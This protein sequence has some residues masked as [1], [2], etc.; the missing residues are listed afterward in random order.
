MLDQDLSHCISE[1]C[2]GP[3]DV[4]RGHQTIYDSNITCKF[5][6]LIY[7]FEAKTLPRYIF[8][9][10]TEQTFFAVDEAIDAMLLFYLKSASKSYFHITY[11]LEPQRNICAC[12]YACLFNFWLGFFVRF[13]FLTLH[14][15]LNSISFARDIIQWCIIVNGFTKLAVNS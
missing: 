1:F 5:E 15:L 13:R 6:W 12:W 9:R 4:E 2:Q 11:F 10:D 3:W 14:I 7:R 8:W